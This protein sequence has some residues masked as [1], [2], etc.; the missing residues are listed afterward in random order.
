MKLFEEGKKKLLVILIIIAI[1]F[2]ALYAIVNRG[3]ISSLVSNLSRVFTPV[4][5]GA[6][7]AYILNPVLRFFEFK[8][9]K[10]IK[11][12]SVLRA[13]SIASTFVVTVV[14]IAA[15]LFMFI[16]SLSKGI[17][18]FTDNYRMYLDNTAQLIN[19]YA[20]KI[21]KTGEDSV[22]IENGEVILAR[23]KEFLNIPEDQPLVRFLTDKAVEYATG[24]VSG[25]TDV[26]LGIFIAIYMLISKEK[27]QA[28]ARKIGNA[29]LSEKAMGAVTKY[30]SITHKTFL[31]YFA[32]KILSSLCV[33]VIMLT[34]MTIFKLPY[35]FVVS[36]IIGITDIIPIFGPF[37]GAIPSFL[38]IFI[39]DPADAILFIIL[40]LVVQQIEGNIISPKILGDKTGISSLSVII[41]I[42]VMGEYFG[43]VGMII[44]V[45]VF[46]VGIMIAKEI[47]ETKLLKKKMST[48]LTDYYR[49]DDVIDPHRHHVPL[50]RRIVYRIERAFRR[51]NKKNNK[52]KKENAYARFEHEE[53]SEGR[54]NTMTVEVNNDAETTENGEENNG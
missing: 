47:I 42:I 41:A 7:L 24:L 23:V 46:A 11:N 45:P 1:A 10:K 33:M 14:A 36:A 9:Y 2:V 17:S 39:V 26:I 4:I 52:P 38:I 12:K 19:E 8:V 34:L 16:P 18:D 3:E 31:S 25:V 15:F 32:G 49:K 20:R 40:I 27:L 48:E 51:K 22:Y 53:N 50:L 6:G 30:A 13:L 29:V 54:G 43:I 21:L 5:I 28:Q 35:P 37:L 44:G